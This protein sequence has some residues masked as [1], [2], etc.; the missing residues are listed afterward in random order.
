MS[1]FTAFPKL[2]TVRHFIILSQR[3]RN[4]PICLFNGCSVLVKH[5]DNLLLN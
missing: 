4:E 5:H 3:N 2:I 1:L